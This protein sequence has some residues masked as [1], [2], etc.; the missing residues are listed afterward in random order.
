MWPFQI[1][2][3]HDLAINNPP[4]WLHCVVNSPL[5]QA[6]TTTGQ[7]INPLIVGIVTFNPDIGRLKQLQGALSG[8]GVSLCIIDNGSANTR[9]ISSAFDQD[10]GVDLILNEENMGI[11]SAIN[12]LLQRARSRGSAYIMS[13]D[14]DSMFPQ[15]YAVDMLA[16]FHALHARH[17]RLGALG[18]RVFDVRT[19]TFEPFVSFDFSWQRQRHD[20]QKL[21][22][23]YKKADFLISSGTILSVECMEQVGAMRDS[24]FIDSVDLEWAFR[25]TSKGWH[26]AGCDAMTVYQEIGIGIVRIPLLNLHVRIHQPLRYYYMTRNRMFLYRQS[27]TK[28]GWLLRDIPRS[29]LKFL[30]LVATSPLRWDIA[31]EHARGVRDSFKL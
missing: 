2:G 10:N 25:A 18:A 3:G 29:V 26:L 6:A 13:V 31:K 11:A 22:A 27:Y 4:K 12:Q 30:F 8:A 17:P 5:L 28:W 24:L 16:N 7:P 9:D 20:F 14:Q 15:G 21:D 23:P 19:N 1:A